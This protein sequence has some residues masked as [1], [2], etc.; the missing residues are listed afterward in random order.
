MPPESIAL[1]EKLAVIVGPVGVL[2]IIL[3]FIWLRYKRNG[4]NHRSEI[5]EVIHNDHDILI[6]IET[7]VDNIK[8]V[9]AE[10]K[11]DVKGL[12]KDSH[13]HPVP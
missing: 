8:E 6:R 12:M 1:I 13:I 4:N 10:V 11:D 3:F 5:H 9:I 2:A 7:N